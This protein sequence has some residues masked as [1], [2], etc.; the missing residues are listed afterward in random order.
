MQVDGGRIVQETLAR[1]SK[2]E[3][4]EVLL[5]QPYKK[6]RSVYVMRQTGM[7]LLVEL[8][9]ARREYEVEPKK[10]KKRLKTVCK[11][12]FPRSKKIWL[13]YCLTEEVTR[14]SGIKIDL[15]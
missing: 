8:G 9:F 6:D 7:Y 10:L 11:K 5:L 15:G 12:E 14:V 1:L 4:G 13:T 2:V 3:D